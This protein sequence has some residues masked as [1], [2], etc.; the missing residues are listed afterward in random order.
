[1]Q[2]AVEEE[3]LRKALVSQE[4]PAEVVGAVQAEVVAL[5]MP[6]LQVQ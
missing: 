3:G 6:V 2:E 1:M 4:A 5:V